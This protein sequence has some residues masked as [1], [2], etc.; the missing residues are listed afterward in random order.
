MFCSIISIVMKFIPTGYRDYYTCVDTNMY[1]T[2]RQHSTTWRQSRKDESW[3]TAEWGRDGVHQAAVWPLATR[4]V[5][6]CLT[7]VKHWRPSVWTHH[8]SVT[9]AALAASPPARCFQHQLL[10]GVAPVYLVDDCRLL[11]TVERPSTWT[12]EA[13]TDLRPLETISKSHL[14]GDRSA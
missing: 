14:F 12:T 4:T 11:S 8:T 7:L 3:L 6:T 10:V 5:A 2:C 9:A 13:G 1:R